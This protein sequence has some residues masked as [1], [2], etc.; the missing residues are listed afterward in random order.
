MSDCKCIC[1]I[2]YD[3]V[4]MEIPTTVNELYELVINDFD[5]E[6][7][8]YSRAR[9]EKRNVKYSYSDRG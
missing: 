5:V 6:K 9:E 8:L 2:E 4:T 1:I 3:I 7:E